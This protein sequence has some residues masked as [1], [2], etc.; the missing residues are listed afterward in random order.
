MKFIILT[1][2]FC[3]SNTYAKW[4]FIGEDNGINYWYD[5]DVI[6]RNDLIDVRVLINL[7]IKNKY[8]DRS[9][10]GDVRINCKS[11]VHKTL[12]NY[13]YPLE[14]AQGKAR[15]SNTTPD[16][17]WSKIPNTSYLMTIAEVA[18]K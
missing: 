2:F 16:I 12:S 8:G 13:S 4:L 15:S 6:K 5:S 14:S 7:P 11:L 10:L 1:S 18:C 17:E 9:A 3:A